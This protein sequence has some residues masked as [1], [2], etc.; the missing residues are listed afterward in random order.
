MNV[1]NVQKVQGQLGNLSLWAAFPRW[2]YFESKA[3]VILTILP[4]TKGFL[5]K[6]FP[7][8]RTFNGDFIKE[9]SHFSFWA[10]FEAHLAEISPFKDSRFGDFS[11]EC[12]PRFPECHFSWFSNAKSI[13]QNLNRMKLKIVRLVCSMYSGSESTGTFFVSIFFTRNRFL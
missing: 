7:I 13:H 4:K 1:K 2:P 10:K 11:M 8:L 12:C 6:K 5:I 3:T 9:N